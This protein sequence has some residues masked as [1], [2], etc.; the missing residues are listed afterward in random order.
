MHANQVASTR[1]AV[2]DSFA[3]VAMHSA[4]Q[5]NA[6]MERYPDYRQALGE[7]DHAFWKTDALRMLADCQEQEMRLIIGYGAQ[8]G[9]RVDDLAATRVA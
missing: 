5:A 6:L 3:E 4:H 8:A 1:L 9:E 7:H 2:I